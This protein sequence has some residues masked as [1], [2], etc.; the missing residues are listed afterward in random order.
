MLKTIGDFV[1]W[2]RKG[3]GISSFREFNLRMKEVRGYINHYQ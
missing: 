2:M 1:Y 3:R